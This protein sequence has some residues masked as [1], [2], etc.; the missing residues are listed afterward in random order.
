MNFSTPAG[1]EKVGGYIW[2]FTVV[3]IVKYFLIRRVDSSKL[4]FWYGPQFK[5]QKSNN[6]LAYALVK[7]VY[8]SHLQKLG[9]LWFKLSRAI[10]WIKFGSERADSILVWCLVYCLTARKHALSVYSIHIIFWSTQSQ[11]LKV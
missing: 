5:G 1:A 3:E 11:N 10:L 6:D 7:R 9:S 4:L 8:L 2:G